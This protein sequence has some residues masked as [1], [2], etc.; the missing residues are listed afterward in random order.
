M[1]P[2]RSEA[3]ILRVYPWSETSCVVPMYT[4]THGKT[5]V[6]AKGAWRP[7][8]PFEGALD[9]LAICRVVFIPKPG[10]AL[11]LL[12]EAKLERRF[13]PAGR[14]L[15]RLYCGYYVSELLDRL[16]ERDQPQAD[17]YDLAEATLVAFAAED[18]E[19]RAAVLRFELQMLRILGHLPEWNRCI[20]CN[21]VIAEEVPMPFAPTAGGMVCTDCMSGYRPLVQLPWAARR[22]LIRLSDE[23][24]RAA[25]LSAVSEHGRAAMRGAMERTFAA[26][27]ERRFNV[28]PYLQELGH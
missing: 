23:N 28:T 3:L 19:P 18:T 8:S 25:D 22:E 9:L 17:L 12:T 2:E 24:W 4:R 15:L 1:E 26:L 6:L 7:K 27:L 21:A 14:Q 5:A 20:H 13:R 11:G 16:T 10:D